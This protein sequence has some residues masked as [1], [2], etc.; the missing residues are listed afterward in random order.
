M[1]AAVPPKRE[2]LGAGTALR[3]NA[4]PKSLHDFPGAAARNMCGEGGGE[5]AAF[6]ELISLYLVL[7]VPTGHDNI[8]MPKIQEPGDFRRDDD[9]RRA[10]LSKPMHQAIDL[11]LGADINAARW[12]VENENVRMRKH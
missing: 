7:Q 11:C 2:L 12:L 6:V 5:N 1:G 3:P 9:P 10:L 4:E 8:G